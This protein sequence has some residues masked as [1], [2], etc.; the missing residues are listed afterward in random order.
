MKSEV[1]IEPELVER[2][3]AHRVIPTYRVQDGDLFLVPAEF[4]RNVVKKHI[5]QHCGVV[6]VRFIPVHGL[7]GMVAFR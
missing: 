4:P 7:Q 2:D 5:E 1:S 6:D 3:E